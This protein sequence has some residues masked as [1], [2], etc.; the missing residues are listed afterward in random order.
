M[1]KVVSGNIQLLMFVHCVANRKDPSEVKVDTWHDEYFN[2]DEKIEKM[3]DENEKMKREIARRTERYVKNEQQYREEI[4]DLERELQMKRREEQNTREAN[5]ANVERINQA[6]I[7]NIE[8]YE[9]QL[10]VL[11]DEQTKDLARKYKSQISRTKKSIE[12]EKAKSGD[13]A[14][15]EAER[16]NELQH[17]LELI[18]NIAQRTETENRDLQRKNK[19]LKSKFEK[20]ETTRELLVKSLVLQKKENKKMQQEIQAYK[21]EL[22]ELEKAREE[23]KVDLDNIEEPKLFGKDPR[24]RA[25]NA[26]FKSMQSGKGQRSATGDVGSE[27]NRRTANFS[28]TT[29]R[30]THAAALSRAASNQA[31]GP[32]VYMP[33]RKVETEEEKLLRFDRVMEKLRKMM[34]HERRLLK[35]ARLQYNKELASKTELEILLKQA[36]DKVR[37]ERKQHKR[38]AQKKE[39]TTQPGLGVGVN[40]VT[41][42]QAAG[43]MI[44]TV[45]GTNGPGGAFDED[46]ELNQHER[47]RVIELMLS[48]ERVISLLYEKTFPMTTAEHNTAED[49]DDMAQLDRQ[50]Q[51]MMMQQQMEHEQNQMQEQRD[52]YGAEEGFDYQMDEQQMAYAQ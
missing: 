41:P 22:V 24:V 43:A 47:E 28:A 26:G 33:P 45:G 9:D 35:T 39:Y 40:L 7:D 50:Q 10:K 21:K 13:K 51:M 11:Q 23:Q 36:V 31:S 38:H 17:H 25:S 27:M 12:Q 18:T 14:A 16:E 15:E 30:S 19:G 37:S 1:K 3:R 49:M 34:Q 52:D 5:Q 6:I 48:Q 8:C 4:N 32:L 42:A 44:G 29:G 46:N 20:Q 2:L